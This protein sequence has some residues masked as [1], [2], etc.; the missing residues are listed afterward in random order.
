MRRV[1]VL[2]P[3]P[4]AS[5]TAER[6]RSM[7]LEPVTIPLFAMEAVPWKAPDTGEFDG[8]L[9]TSANAVRHGGSQLGQLRE[10]PVYAVGEATADAAHGAGFEVRAT[11]D[12]GV[13]GLL[14]SINRALKLLHLAGEDRREPATPSQRMT[15]V[16]VY[17]ARELPVDLSAAAYCVALVHSPRAARRF[18]ELVTEPESIAIAAIS[19]AAAEAA[20]DGWKSISVAEQPTDEAVLALA[21]QLCD[22][23]PRE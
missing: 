11:G 20:G 22:K 16:S 4:G 8:L 23:L 18:A 6:A 3:E 13:D 19:A 15:T 1:L 5:A 7:G 10:L 14:G 9:L 17:R 21:A 2:R 12:N